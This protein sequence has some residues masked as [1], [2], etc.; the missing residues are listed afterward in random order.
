M[1]T[2]NFSQKVT[3]G[4][5]RSEI[6][7]NSRYSHIQNVGCLPQAVFDLLHKN[8]DCGGVSGNFLLFDKKG[9]YEICSLSRAEKLIDK[10]QI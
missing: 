10:Y 9:D 3:A 1:A 4:V 5:Y 2:L 6:S 8:H 7:D